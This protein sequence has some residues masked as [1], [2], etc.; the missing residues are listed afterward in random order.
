MNYIILLVRE[1]RTSYLRMTTHKVGEDFKKCLNKNSFALLLLSF[2][3]QDRNSPA[4]KKG[5]ANI[6]YRHIRIM[7]TH[8]DGKHFKIFIFNFSFFIYIHLRRIS[9]KVIHFHKRIAKDFINFH[10]KNHKKMCLNKIDSFD[11]L[12]I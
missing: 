12:L 6:T 7:N 2:F 5:I 3:F 10:K 1:A 11:L 8:R 9:K 4:C